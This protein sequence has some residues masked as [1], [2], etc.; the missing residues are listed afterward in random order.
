MQVLCTWLHLMV[1]GLRSPGKHN[2]M[3]REGLK[4][5]SEDV[6]GFALSWF[7]QPEDLFVNCC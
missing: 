3:R 2:S 4:G 5:L 6:V 1:E 7:R